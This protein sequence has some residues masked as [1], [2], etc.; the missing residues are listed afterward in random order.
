MDS[1]VAGVPAG[2]DI[3]M[4]LGHTPP[5]MTVATHI[6]TGTT[7]SANPTNQTAG[8]V[9][10][11]CNSPPYDLNDWKAYVTAMV[12]RYPTVQYWEIWNEITYTSSFTG[13]IGGANDSPSSGTVNYGSG[14]DMYNIVKA[15]AQIIHAAGGK[16][17]SPSVDGGPNNMARI[18]PLLRDLYAGGYIDVIAVHTY[19][20]LAQIPDLNTS[21]VCTMAYAKQYRQLLK[22][23][24]IPMTFPIWATEFGWVF[25]NADG[26]AIEASF[27]AAFPAQYLDGQQQM[28]IIMRAFLVHA[29]AGYSRACWYMWDEQSMGLLEPSTNTGGATASSV[30]YKPAVVALQILQSWILNRRVSDI[31]IDPC[32]GT[33]S[34]AVTDD[35]GFQG[36]IV[37]N[38]NAFPQILP[39]PP[40][41]T[42]ITQVTMPTIMPTVNQTWPSNTAASSL[43]LALDPPELTPIPNPISMTENAT[44]A[45]GYAQSGSYRSSTNYVP[46]KLVTTPAPSG[47]PNYSTDDQQFAGIGT[48]TT[49]LNYNSSSD[50]S[51]TSGASLYLYHTPVLLVK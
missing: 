25:D 44:Y 17:I 31:T 10:Q 27:A 35:K 19:S 20:G 1:A 34:V 51:E 9:P 2:V 50:F 26:T 12:N 23:A 46:Y 24:G 4:T 7:G 29:A 39:L 30:T 42:T 18:I 13:T 47:G 36:L 16:V 33:A 32:N 28:G 37:W 5:A 21:N 41:Y 14:S 45:I 22:A 40:G 6:G 11:G 49:Q 3:I 15:A 48:Q 43:P 8:E 38:T